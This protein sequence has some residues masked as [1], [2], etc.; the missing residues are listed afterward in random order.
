MTNIKGPPNRAALDNLNCLVLKMVNKAK[1]IPIPF[2]PI[3]NTVFVISTEEQTG[4]L[5]K[6]NTALICRF[7]LVVITGREELDPALNIS[8][9]C[10]PIIGSHCR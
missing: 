6:V 3:L 10:S 4:N 9:P 5:G 8:G 1:V 7:R 2:R